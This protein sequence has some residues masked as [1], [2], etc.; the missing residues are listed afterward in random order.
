MT[1]VT[2]SFVYMQAARPIQTDMDLRPFLRAMNENDEAARYASVTHKLRLLLSTLC[3]ALPC[4]GTCLLTGSWC[5]P[6]C[7]DARV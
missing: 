6:V 2:Y 1:C 4:D 7:A 3:A 5:L